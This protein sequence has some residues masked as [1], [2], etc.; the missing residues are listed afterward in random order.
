MRIDYCPECHKAGLRY[1][2]PEGRDCNG[3]TQQD[4]YNDWYKSGANKNEIFSSHGPKKWCPRC[5]KW[6]GPMAKEIS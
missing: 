6:V 5:K 3:K 2:N 4:R 1:A